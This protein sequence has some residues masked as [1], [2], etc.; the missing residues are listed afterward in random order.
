MIFIPAPNEAKVI[1]SIRKIRN[2][3]YA[4]LR[5]TF[6]M[7]DK[8]N[9]DANGVLRGL[10]LGAGIVDY[11]TLENGGD[12]GVYADAIYIQNSKTDT[13]R[14]KFYKVN[15]KRG[16]RRFS[17]GNIRKR[18]KARDL[19]EGDLLYISAFQKADGAPQIY[20]INLTHNIPGDQEI[21]HAIGADI[22]NQTF[23]QMKPRLREILNGGFFDNSKG[24]GAFASKDV[25]DTLEALLGIETN[26]RNDADYDGVIEVKAK[27]EGKTLDTLFTLRPHFEGTAVAQCEPVDRNR[28][29]AF[30][31]HYGYDSDKHPGYSSLYITI[32]SGEA[33]QNGHG[34]YLQV[35]E[36]AESVNIIK[37]DDLTKK[38]EI[39]AFWPFRELKD[40]L[41]RKHPSTIWVKAEHRVV[42]GLVQFKYNE[43][44]FSRAPQFTAFLS[45]IKAGKVTYDWRGYTTK[46]GKY[47][48]KNHGNA[49]RIK[50][51]ARAEL[52]CEIEKVDV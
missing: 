27:G 42:N 48:G 17:I 20:I 52:F 3:E 5:L 44:E 11:D 1:S 31:R 45:L 36:S 6:T 24:V 2:E 28:V 38:H 47:S 18:A 29:S 26:N 51:D 15:N 4:L 41:Y 7:I 23:A 30:A 32:G 33:P 12:N 46:S 10:M 34:F 50:P 14:L 49:W 22:I 9:L 13:I 43:I 8:N 16:D 19:N 40:Q 25:G 37:V 21:L 39:A 35:D